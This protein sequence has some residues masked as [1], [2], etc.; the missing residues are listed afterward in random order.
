MR[1]YG[2]NEIEICFID[3]L[4]GAENLSHFPGRIAGC[5]A[6]PA[7]FW[8]AAPPHFEPCTFACRSEPVLNRAK[9]IAAMIQTAMPP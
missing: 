3:C 5:R 9:L 1:D 4:Y 6:H 2:F 8:S 7:V